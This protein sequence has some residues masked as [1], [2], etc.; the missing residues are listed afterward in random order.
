M[1]TA[2]IG[3]EH[4]AARTRGLLWLGLGLL[5]AIGLV[6]ASRIQLDSAP[7]ASVQAEKPL[8][9]SDAHCNQFI[10]I[11]K[12]AYGADWKYRLDPRDTTCARQVQ[13]QWQ[14]EWTARQPTTPMPS[15]TI[16]IN[17][18]AAP[19]DDATTAPADSRIRNPETY[20]LNL[21]SLARSRYGA[22]WMS[23]VTPEDAANCGDAIRAAGSH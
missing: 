12:A 13:A 9:V 3:H 7:A 4:G 5:L 19:D 11:A 18:P 17:Q 20:C 2:E 1:A 14:Q 22:D 23:K 10:A 21:I 6:V 8:S 15:G 16:S